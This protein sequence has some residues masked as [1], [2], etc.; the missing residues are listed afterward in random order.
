MCSVSQNGQAP[1]IAINTF[2]AAPILVETPC[3][4]T[5]FFELF[6]YNCLSWLV[7]NENYNVEPKFDENH[8][9]I[10]VGSI[11]PLWQ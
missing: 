3:D 8:W 4:G 7:M 6:G 2:Q 11:D 9:F 1:L 5:R 10:D